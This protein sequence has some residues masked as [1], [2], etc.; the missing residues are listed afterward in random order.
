MCTYLCPYPPRSVRCSSPSCAVAAGMD[1]E[2]A[3]FCCPQAFSA[4]VGLV[5]VP[6]E[7]ED[8]GVGEVATVKDAKMR[9]M[10]GGVKRS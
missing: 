1:R 6:V 3:C 5:P 2:D 10:R 4:S 7:M 9:G 8:E